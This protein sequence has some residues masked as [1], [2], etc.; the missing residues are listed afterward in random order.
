MGRY[1]TQTFP[2]QPNPQ[3]GPHPLERSVS[4]RLTGW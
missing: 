1:P 3:A 4:W 2:I